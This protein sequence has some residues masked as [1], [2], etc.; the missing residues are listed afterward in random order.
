MIQTN[1]F[2]VKHV[3]TCRVLYPSTL[4]GIQMKREAFWS[5]TEVH[6]NQVK[7]DGHLETYELGRNGCGTACKCHGCVVDGEDTNF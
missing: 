7:W 3:E 2:K 6:D 1:S 4:E 5:K